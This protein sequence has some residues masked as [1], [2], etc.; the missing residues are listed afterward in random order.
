MKKKIKKSKNDFLKISEA[1]GII[2]QPAGII[3]QEIRRI[4]LHLKHLFRLVFHF[5][6]RFLHCLDRATA[7]SLLNTVSA[8]ITRMQKY[9]TDEIS[10]RFVGTPINQFYNGLQDPRYRGFGMLTGK[11]K[12]AEECVIP[13]A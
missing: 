7:L 3:K 1:V 5:L 11:T 2:R 10:C 12:G 13:S 6:C 9:E 8:C 4:S